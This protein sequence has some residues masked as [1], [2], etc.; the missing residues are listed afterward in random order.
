MIKLTKTQ[1][2]FLPTLMWYLTDIN[3]G[4]KNI[5]KYLDKN[6]SARLAQAGLDLGNRGQGK[7]TLLAYAYIEVMLDKIGREV[8]PIDIPRAF[9]PISHF[10]T[11]NLIS[12]II[13]IWNGYYASDYPHLKLENKL[14]TSTLRLVKI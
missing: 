10:R 2:K 4:N 3:P 1:K 7:T 6:F 13:M 14:S 8:Y 11:K 12:D 9:E 5:N